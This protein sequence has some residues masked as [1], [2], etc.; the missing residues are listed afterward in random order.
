MTFEEAFRAH[1]PEVRRWVVWR[2]GE[3]MADDA[4]QEGFLYAWLNWET[5][6]TVQNLKAWLTGVT[7]YAALAML[8]GDRTTH[9]KRTL[10]RDIAPFHGRAAALSEPYDPESD[11]R[12]QPAEQ[13]LAMYIAQLRSH[14]GCLGPAQ[15]EVLAALAE[16][17][18]AQE[19]ADR[20]GRSQ[21]A[22]SAAVQLGR[23]RMRER[24][25][26]SKPHVWG[27]TA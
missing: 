2:F 19:F 20:T 25:G 17:E 4:T 22:V 21:Q 9:S 3:E 7:K 11:P 12:E 24:L 10:K 8:R 23:K 26:D 1:H 15:Q 16:G 27:L 5:G 14:F 18:T 13:G 6:A